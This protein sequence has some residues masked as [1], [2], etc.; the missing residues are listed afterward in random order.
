MGVQ[1][2]S[3]LLQNIDCEFLLEL[4]CQGGFNEYPQLY[5]S[6]KSLFCHLPLVT[7]IDET[8]AEIRSD[9]NWALR[10]ITTKPEDQWS[11]KRSPESAAY[12]NKRLNIM[13]FNPSAGAGEALGPFSFFQNNQY[14]VHLPISCWLFPSNDILTVFPHSNAWATHVDLAIKLVKVITGS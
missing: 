7:K 2:F 4:P 14:S 5:V 12:T 3:F 6:N 10:S 1:F 11:C 13:V 8:L 9:T